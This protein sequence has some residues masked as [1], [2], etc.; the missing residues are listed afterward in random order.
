MAGTGHARQRAARQTGNPARSAGNS[1]RRAVSWARK[2]PNSALRAEALSHSE[3][4]DICRDVSWL[5]GY[6]Y[7]CAI[8]NGSQELGDD[9]SWDPVSRLFQTI[10]R[11]FTLWHSEHCVLIITSTESAMTAPISQTPK[12]LDRVRAACRVRHYSRRTEDA[13]HDW[14]ER[15]HPLSWH[16][17]PAKR[18]PS[19]RG[20]TRSSRIS[21]L[22][23]MWLPQ[24]R[25]RHN[26]RP[27][28]PVSAAFSTAPLDRINGVVRACAAFKRPPSSCSA[29]TKVHCI[30]AHLEG[31]YRLI[32]LLQYG[33]R[34]PVVGMPGA[35]G[36]RIWTAA[37]T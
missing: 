1:G 8:L 28:L 13:Y 36:S 37:T 34:A 20:E 35:G 19:P 22:T 11:P 4:F 27:A 3:H 6:L 5:S 29:P 12:L 32:A 10:D 24:R 9:F 14:I 30:I 7:Y 26:M 21:R 15:L 25:I 16:S 2:A 31:V 18:W 17:P 33:H 23:G